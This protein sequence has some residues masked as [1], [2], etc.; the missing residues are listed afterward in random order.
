M[1]TVLYVTF[2]VRQVERKGTQDYTHQI[3]KTWAME[4]SFNLPYNWQYVLAVKMFRKRKPHLFNKLN[5]KGE[6][7]VVKP[8]DYI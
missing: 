8:F 3:K 7:S 5:I 1:Q 2:P 4:G 6:V